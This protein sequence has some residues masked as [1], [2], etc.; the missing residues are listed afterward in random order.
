MTPIPHQYIDRKTCGI[1]TE[2]LYG[3]RLVNALYAGARECPSALFRALSSARMS[4][5]LGFVIYDMPLGAKLTGARRFSHDLGVNFAECLDPPAALDTARKIFERKIR[6]WEIRPMPPEPEAVISP[7]DARMLAGSFCRNSALFLKEKFF[8]FEALLGA[9][10]RQW[11]RAFKDGDFAV[12]RLTPDK[13]HYNHAPVS[14]K[15]LDIYE[16]PGA[17]SPCNPGAV[18]A[19]A[20]PFSRNRRVVTVMDTDV[21]GGTGVG[22]VAMIE[23]VALMIGDIVQCYSDAK[24]DDPRQVTPGMF[25]K[26][27]QVK[28][29]YRPGSSTDVLIF[30]KDRVT[31]SPDI[32]ANL[33]RTDVQTRFSEGFGRPLVETEVA[34]RSQIAA[35]C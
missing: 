31:F 9:E 1:R 5:F 14:G 28:S 13:Y 24:Y 3:D 23:V 4:E 15:I 8:S 17:Y 30:Q 20:A 35:G 18:I 26:K 2:K 27:G 12:F 10:K 22:R 19:L 34:L 7:A 6:Y 16:I 11:L 25:L 29:L 21:P 32:V 33:Y